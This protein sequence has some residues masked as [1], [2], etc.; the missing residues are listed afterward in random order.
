MFIN[1][2]VE[3]DEMNCDECKFIH[4]IFCNKLGK[5]FSK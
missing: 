5:C 3:I 4:F 2:D 1:V